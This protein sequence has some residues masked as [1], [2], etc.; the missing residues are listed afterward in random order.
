MSHEFVSLWNL[1]GAEEHYSWSS[2]THSLTEI[3]LNFMFTV[4]INKSTY[5]KIIKHCMSVH[6]KGMESSV[7]QAI[8]QVLSKTN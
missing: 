3:K 2:T 8:N 4:D 6:K 5:K 7:T 1:I